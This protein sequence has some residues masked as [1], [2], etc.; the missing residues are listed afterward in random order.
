MRRTVVYFLFSFSGLRPP[1]LQKTRLW[2]RSRHLHHGYIDNVCGRVWLDAASLQLH[3]YM[4][5][6]FSLI[7]Q[8]HTLRQQ[9]RVWP[10]NSF[11]V[12]AIHARVHKLVFHDSFW[13]VRVLSKRQRGG[14]LVHSHDDSCVHFRKVHLSHQP[15]NI[16]EWALLVLKTCN[17]RRVV[18][19]WRFVYP[20]CV[21][22]HRKLEASQ[23]LCRFCVTLERNHRNS[24]ALFTEKGDFIQYLVVIFD[25]VDQELERAFGG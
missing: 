8:T 15:P 2:P 24:M 11:R 17:K 13:V 6:V 4:G 23:L 14:V 25:F 21:V 12:R 22:A 19:Q 16:L 1:D 10:H 20:S 18:L 9:A 3:H 7:R 5:H